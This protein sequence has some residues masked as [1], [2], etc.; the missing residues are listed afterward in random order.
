M[1]VNDR[2]HIQRLRRA[3]ESS[4]SRLEPFRAR[5][6]Y[7]IKQMVGE[8][9]GDHGADKDTRVNMIELASN[10][11][12][13]Q[14]IARPPQVLCF[15]KDPKWLQAGKKLEIVLNQ[16]LKELN[17]HIQ[18]QRCV[19]AAL[20]SMGICKVGTRVS[21]TVVEA[22][23]E[24]DRVEPYVRN[25]LLDDWVH[26]MTARHMEEVGFMG[27][28]YR[29][30][31]ELAR[32]NPDFVKS[33]REGLKSD[34][35]YAYNE[36]GDSRIH[37]ISQG[38]SSH[39]EYEPKVELW[40][41]WMPRQQQLVTL[42]PNPDD[43][44]LRVVDW[45]GPENGPFHVL[46]FNEVDGQTL[47]LAPAMLWSGLH[48][49]INGMWRK[50]ERQAQ[51]QK[52]VGVAR[53]EDSEDAEAIRQTAD[54]EIV[55]VT[56]PDAIQEKR[57]GGVDNNTFAFLLQSKDM[58]SWL[59]GNLDLLG[60]LGA[61]SGT[62]GQDQQL[63][64]SSS[65]RISHMQDQVMA[66][67]KNVITD[68]GFYLWDD[69]IE[70][71]PVSFNLP[72]VDDWVT[73]LTPEERE[74]HPYYFHEVDIHP[75]SMTF[76]SPTERLNSVNQVMMNVLLPA[77]PM[78]QEQGLALNLREYLRIFSKYA[79]L[80]EL[81]NLITNS[82]RALQPLGPQPTDPAAEEGGGGPDGRT[83]SPSVTRRIN[84]RVSRPGATRQGAEQS[85]IQTLM[86]GN[87]QPSEGEAMSRH[88]GG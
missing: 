25:I 74:I 1:N 62:L 85:L 72:G 47:P 44:P 3:M 32:E 30:P 70:T 81:N 76:Q 19:K 5:H 17:V 7:G 37:T 27:H 64:A 45:I 86:G 10:V 66:F 11:Y 14:L 51:R 39:E 73:E 41:V 35:E 80:P 36:D 69:P 8:N 21:G 33:V 50:L 16:K 46:S 31:V 6:R 12:E 55:G 56:N 79:D 75:Y 26:D 40:E 29:I 88:Y 38:Q 20:F 18:L 13:R 78:L 71:Y 77:M 24:I 87:P 54:G 58:F 82:E 53:G 52:V 83:E 34:E 59:A 60:G 65:R 63:M 57:F 42:G 15:T 48:D 22:G 61:S 4:R 9:Y 67:T 68:L 43:P 49:Q 84:E 23:Y 28:R 2:L